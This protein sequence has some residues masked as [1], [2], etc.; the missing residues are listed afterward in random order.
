M[1][2][3]PRG[4]INLDMQNFGLD[5]ICHSRLLRDPQFLHY[6]RVSGWLENVRDLPM[7]PGQLAAGV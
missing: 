3:I 2:V 6:W 5:G 7:G 4:G 1:L